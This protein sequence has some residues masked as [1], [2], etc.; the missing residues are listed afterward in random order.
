[1]VQFV[2]PA[3]QHAPMGGQFVQLVLPAPCHTPPVFWQH[4]CDW[5]NMQVL[6]LKQ[7]APVGEHVVPSPR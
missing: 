3:E 1:M 4:D 5:L 2:P 7:H 6:P